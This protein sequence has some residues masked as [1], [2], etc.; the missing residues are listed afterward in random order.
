MLGGS[1]CGFVRRVS[2]RV[3][4]AAGDCARFRR[5]GLPVGGLCA[6]LP[7]RGLIGFCLVFDCAAV[8][9]VLGFEYRFL[10]AVVVCGLRGDFRLRPF[11]PDFAGFEWA[12]RGNMRE[13]PYKG[14]YSGFS[15]FLMGA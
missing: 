8:F 9:A 12:G 15:G 4:R 13:K 2:A 3:N 14:V 5:R 1:P 10:C 7:V 6:G 11:F